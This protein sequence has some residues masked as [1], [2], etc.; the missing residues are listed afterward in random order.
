[1]ADLDTLVGAPRARYDRVAAA[2]D[3]MSEANKA[4]FQRIIADESYTHTQVAAA[5]REI[6]YD[7]DRK[8]VHQFREKLAM[9]RVTL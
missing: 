8:Q 2:Y 5:M 4:S 7:V 1:M 9:G 6:G 3:G